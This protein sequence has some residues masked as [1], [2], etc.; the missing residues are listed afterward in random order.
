MMSA[1][2]KASITI[3]VVATAL[4]FYTPPLPWEWPN[5]IFSICCMSMIWHDW[6]VLSDDKNSIIHSCGITMLAIGSYRVLPYAKFPFQPTAS[7]LRNLAALV[8]IIGP[9]EAAKLFFTKLSWLRVWKRIWLVSL[10]I[11]IS[12]CAYIII[13]YCLTL[14]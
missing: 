12:G 13:A 14:R 2:K 8:A 3:R 4:Y 1:R 5:M 6:F 9:P 11:L 10:F 7:I